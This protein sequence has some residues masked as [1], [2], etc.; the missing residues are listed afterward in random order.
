[1]AHI[2]NPR[3]GIFWF[4][5]P[6]SRDGQPQPSR[7]AGWFEEII[8]K[9]PTEEFDASREGRRYRTYS[10]YRDEVWPSIQSAFSFVGWRGYDFYPAGS[11]GW[12]EADQS[13]LL[14]IDAALNSR[15]FLDVIAE[16]T[17]IS[18]DL[19]VITTYERRAAGRVGLPEPGRGYDANVGYALSRDPEGDF[20]TSSVIEDR[21]VGAL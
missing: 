1:M 16:Q 12:C 14:L 5:S 8:A 9:L 19:A 18:L 15:P 6:P 3:I 20:D 17:G 4:I 13:A 21:A 10:L 7:M 2:Q 11:V